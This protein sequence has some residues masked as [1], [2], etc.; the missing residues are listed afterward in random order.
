M[1]NITSYVDRFYEKVN[2]SYYAFAGILIGFVSVLASLLIYIQIDLEF[3]FQT[4]YLSHL[5]GVPIG[6]A[7]GIYA[8]AI[9]F[10]TGMLLIV[11]IRLLF[12]IYLTR[13]VQ[14]MGSGKTLAIT[15]LIFGFVATFGYLLVGLEPYSSNLF[16]HLM[17][18]VIYFVGAT[19][20]GII[21][22]ITEFRTPNLPK[23]L[24]VTGI[25]NTLLFLVFSVL[26]IIVEV[27]GI[28]TIPEPTLL[29]WLVFLSALI[30]LFVHGIY[31]HKK[32][33]NK[34]KE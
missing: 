32:R 3:S 12:L 20:F 23:F 8:S 26:L 13:A 19:L 1:E 29:E 5:G 30:W 25:I 24:P 31:F 15:S 2:G 33:K 6:A 28:S 21:F 14:K 9:I 10:N 11:P 4:R 7:D 17:G 34:I 18:A 27:A 22:I 16:L